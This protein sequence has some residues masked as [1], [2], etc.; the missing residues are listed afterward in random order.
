MFPVALFC[1]LY[2]RENVYLNYDIDWWFETLLASQNKP[3]GQQQFGSSASGSNPGGPEGA[4]QH[5]LSGDADM[6]ED[7]TTAFGY[8]VHNGNGSADF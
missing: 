1:C 6:T 2:I 7:G 3:P 5:V 4:Q 8:S